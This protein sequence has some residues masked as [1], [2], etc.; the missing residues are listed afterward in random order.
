MLKSPRE[1]QLALSFIMDR[2]DQIPRERL[3]PNVQFWGSTFFKEHPGWNLG[4]I[5][6]GIVYLDEQESMVKTDHPVIAMFNTCRAKKGLE[7]L[8]PDQADHG[9]FNGNRAD[10]ERCVTA[11]ETIL[12]KDLLSNVR[13]LFLDIPMNINFENK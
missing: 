12:R 11:I 2:F 10:I 1:L 9:Y 4:N 3:N 5:R 8:D 6:K 7:P 13:E